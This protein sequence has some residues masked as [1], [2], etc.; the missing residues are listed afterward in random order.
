MTDFYI[1]TERA[2][3]GPFTGIELREA[4]LAR[5][6][7]PATQVGG[8]ENGP[9][10]RA[11]DIGL[12]SQKQ[13]PLP[14][15]AG[16][17]VPEFRLTGV[18]DSFD[19]PFKLRE[20]IGF[21]VRGMLPE[22][23][24]VQV[25]NGQP[26]PSTETTSDQNPW[27]TVTRIN[28]LAACLEGRLAAANTAPHPQRVD[29]SHPVHSRWRGERRTEAP[30]ESQIA[31]VAVVQSS[32]VSESPNATNAPAS[33][34]A[35]IA[36][37]FAGPIEELEEDPSLEDYSEQLRTDLR[38]GKPKKS[39]RI[40]ADVLVGGLFVLAIVGVTYWVWPTGMDRQ[41]VIGDWIEVAADG[42]DPTFGISFRADGSCVILDA[43]GGQCWTGDYRWIDHQKQKTGFKTLGDVSTSVANVEPEHRS[44]VAT[45]DD[46]YIHLT[47][48][49]FPAPP[50]LGDKELRD[51]FVRRSGRHLE[52]GY[53]SSINWIRGSR[54]ISVGWIKLAPSRSE[55]LPSSPNWQSSIEALVAVGVPDEARPMNLFEAPIQWNMDMVR[56][57]HLIRYGEHTF[58]MSRDGE[59][60]PYKP[61]KPE[62]GKLDKRD[63]GL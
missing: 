63:A 61:T 19:G 49:L 31:Q 4:A 1:K 56:R 38:R 57:H 45:A 30:V 46:G 7:L 50:K 22:D 37:E 60:K 54:Q 59:M 39:I 29:P 6:V 44:G 58:L 33:R 52:I 27:I 13:T 28:V 41:E 47:G 20:L 42:S 2:V 23:A 24:L 53:I 51:C 21:A 62:F 17:H 16:T 11:G 5:I 55:T 15:P 8:S 25:I 32:P 9:W 26:P 43:G 48:S 14:H 36:D 35:D 10:M 3:C 18:N 34:A 40:C 12:F